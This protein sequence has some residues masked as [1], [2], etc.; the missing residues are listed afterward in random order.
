MTA[1]SADLEN[2]MKLQVLVAT[3]GQTDFS[4]IDAMNIQCDCILANQADRTDDQEQVRPFGTVRMVTTN[5][6]GVGLNRNVGICCAQADYLLFADDDLVYEDGYAETVIRAFGE[7]PQADAIIFNVRSSD[8]AAAARRRSSAR[9]HRLH[10]YNA[11]NYGAVRI[12]V[13]RNALVREN[14]FFSLNFGGGAPFSAGEDSLFIAEMLRRGLK[15]YAYPAV[16]ATVDDKPGSSTWF[17]GYTEKY[18][19][20][21]GVITQAIHRLFPRLMCL[22]FLLRHPNYRK[23]GLTFARAWALMQAGRRGFRQLRPYAAR[24]DGQ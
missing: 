23:S 10:L 3:M 12:A 11:M 21:Q 2:T 14:I 13:R 4:K 20:D 18:Y 17:Q 7:L 19:Y 1:P 9:V 15:L 8:P 5:T 24:Q 16:I 22:Q 6:R